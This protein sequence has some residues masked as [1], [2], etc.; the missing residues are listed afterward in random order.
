MT[1]IIFY[2][3]Y[4]IR[5]ERNFPS[6]DFKY[7]Y[8]EASTRWRIQNNNSNGTGIQKLPRDASNRFRGKIRI[9]AHTPPVPQLDGSRI[10]IIYIL[11]FYININTYLLLFFFFTYRYFWTL[12]QLIQLIAIVI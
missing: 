1:D 8:L 2:S 7:Y 9:R 12:L 6:V 11:Y 3:I 4:D 5:S 10:I